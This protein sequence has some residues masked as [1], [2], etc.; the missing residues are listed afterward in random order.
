MVILS[1]LIV[2]HSSLSRVKHL[3]HGGHLRDLLRHLSLGRH[4]I[5]QLRVLDRAEFVLIEVL[6]TYGL[7]LAWIL[8]LFTVNRVKETSS[9]LISSVRRVLGEPLA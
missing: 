2:A 7:I 4:L 3:A 6:L 5:H 8:L 1:L 9:G